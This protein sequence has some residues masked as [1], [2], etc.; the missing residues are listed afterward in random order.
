MASIT[1][2]RTTHLFPIGSISVT[3]GIVDLIAEE[4]VTLKYLGDIIERHQSGDAGVTCDDTKEANCQALLDGTCII[5][6]Y[7]IDTNKP[8]KGFGENTIWIITEADRSYTTVL[9]PEE[10]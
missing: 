5:S 6:A 7:P 9:L 2:D 3:R 1:E 10:Y 8:S 4:R